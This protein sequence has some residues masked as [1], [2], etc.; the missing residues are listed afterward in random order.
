MTLHLSNLLIVR[1]HADVITVTSTHVLDPFVKNVH[2]QL[3]DDALVVKTPQGLL[4][5]SRAGRGPPVFGCALHHVAMDSERQ[6]A[7][8]TVKVHG[9]GYGSCF[10]W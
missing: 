9:N 2:L 1:E 3:F 4:A 6:S 7:D 8:L 10:S 5:G